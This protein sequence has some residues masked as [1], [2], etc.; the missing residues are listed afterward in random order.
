MGQR[1]Q[2][3]RYPLYFYM[4][5][6]AKESYVKKLSIHESNQR[7][8]VVHGTWELTLDSNVAYNT[9]GH[10][11]FLEDG[12]EYGNILS[13]NIGIATKKGVSRLPGAT[14]STQSDEF[15]A[16][17]WISNPNNTLVNNVAAGSEDSG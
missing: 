8:I 7:C 14:S 4:C 2:Y 3:G 1:G 17:F 12:V 15:A 13:N 10:C 9:M 16:T 11:Y 6:G 5:Q